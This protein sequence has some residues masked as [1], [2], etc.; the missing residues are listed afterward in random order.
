M[1]ATS[2]GEGSLGESSTLFPNNQRYLIRGGETIYLSFYHL[3]KAPERSNGAAQGH[4][5]KMASC[6][7]GTSGIYHQR[8]R[9]VSKSVIVTGVTN[10]QRTDLGDQ[11][12]L[13]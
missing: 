10:T 3:S 6:G 1:H 2:E 5:N 7:V 13:I 11:C 12:Q 9:H 8:G 4:E